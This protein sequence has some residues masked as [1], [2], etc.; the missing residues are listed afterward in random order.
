[1]LIDFNIFLGLFKKCRKVQKHGKF[2]YIHM[3][4]Y[5]T[6]LEHGD[7]IE[8]ELAGRFKV[9]QTQIKGIHEKLNSEIKSVRDDQR[10]MK[11]EINKKVDGIKDE[12]I[13]K[14][15]KII[16]FLQIPDDQQ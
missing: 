6:D 5:T 12:I 9:L 2:E 4:M 14:V 11:T 15:D 13:T 8:Q 10:I 16:N 3:L 7:D 1:M